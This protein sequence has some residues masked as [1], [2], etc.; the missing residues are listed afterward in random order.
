MIFNE[1]SFMSHLNVSSSL[2]KHFSLL[3]RQLVPVMTTAGS[4]IKT[5]G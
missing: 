3:V 5:R 4:T 1:Q 2:N